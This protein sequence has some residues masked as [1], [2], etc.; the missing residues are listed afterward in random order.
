MG[1]GALGKPAGAMGKGPCHV[2]AG[3]SVLLVWKSV[4]VQARKSV[5]LGCKKGE[6]LLHD[7]NFVITGIKGPLGPVAACRWLPGP[8]DGG[9][10]GGGGGDGGTAVV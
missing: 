6:G 1:F 9:G 3:N 8:G 7:G 5:P 10:G 4:H 2:P